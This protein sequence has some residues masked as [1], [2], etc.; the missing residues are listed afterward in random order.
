MKKEDKCNNCP[1]NDKH[2]LI[3]NLTKVNLVFYT[4]CPICYAHICTVLLLF[5]LLLNMIMHIF[6]ESYFVFI[7]LY[8][9]KSLKRESN[10]KDFTHYGWL[11]GND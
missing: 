11:Y 1:R 10:S 5:L 8:D 9:I 6:K 2:L 4:L 7:T 3:W